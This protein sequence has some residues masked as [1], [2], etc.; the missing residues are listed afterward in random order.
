MCTCLRVVGVHACIGLI[1]VC[2]WSW[3]TFCCLL[4]LSL[5]HACSL[6]HTRVRLA[7][8]HGAGT[9][10]QKRQQLNGRQ[11]EHNGVAVS[12]LSTPQAVSALFLLHP[13]AGVVQQIENVDAI[14]VR[15]SIHGLF[16]P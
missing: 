6:A 15:F 13:A 12:L 9:L 4:D 2:V 3:I 5:P 11:G 1:P 16:W 8:K 14:R 7:R 10:T